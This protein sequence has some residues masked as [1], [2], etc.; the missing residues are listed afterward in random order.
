M[1][2]GGEEGRDPL[3]NRYGGFQ[4]QGNI[5]VARRERLKG[6]GVRL[7]GIE[8]TRREKLDSIGG[9]SGNVGPAEQ[10]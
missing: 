3:K 10:K 8:E 5:A 1:D 7:G 2:Q 4:A 9:R 6:E